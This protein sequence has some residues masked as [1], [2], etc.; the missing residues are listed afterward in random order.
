MTHCSFD[1][2]PSTAG[3]RRLLLAALAASVT[4]VTLVS[5]GAA[6]AV[7][8]KLGYD[9]EKDFIGL[10]PIGYMPAALVINKELPAQNFAELIALMKKKDRPF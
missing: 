2:A 3:P 6:P 5:L 1:S 7:Y 9:A 10:A 8:K 4:L